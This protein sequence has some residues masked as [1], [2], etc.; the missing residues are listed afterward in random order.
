MWSPLLIELNDFSTEVL[1]RIANCS[2]LTG[3]VQSEGVALSKCKYAQVLFRPVK[4]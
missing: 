1:F 3:H 2:H 4:M